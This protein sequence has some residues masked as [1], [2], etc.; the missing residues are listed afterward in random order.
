MAEPAVHGNRMGTIGV[1]TGLGDAKEDDRYT[2]RSESRSG[3]RIER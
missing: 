1:L 2:W 3:N